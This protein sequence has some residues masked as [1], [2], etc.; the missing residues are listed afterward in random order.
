LFARAKRARDAEEV[1][2]IPLAVYVAL[3]KKPPAGE[4]NGA[5][6]VARSEPTPRDRAVDEWNR[7]N[8]RFPIA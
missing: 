6:V 7:T 1:L 3:E 4:A 8:P 5:L 2:D